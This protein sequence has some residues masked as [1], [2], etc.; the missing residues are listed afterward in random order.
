MLYLNTY[1]LLYYAKLNTFLLVLQTPSSRILLRY[2]CTGLPKKDDVKLEEIKEIKSELKK[3]GLAYTV[4]IM[5]R[6]G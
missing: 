6:H 4:Y 3:D 5:W 2:S 1:I